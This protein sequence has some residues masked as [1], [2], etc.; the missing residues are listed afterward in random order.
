MWDLSPLTRDGSCV[1]CIRRWILNHWTT[2]EVPW[3]L[4]FKERESGA[5]LAVEWLRLCSSDA[6][7]HSFDPW[8]GN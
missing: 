5:Y 7:R 3:T 6:G 1:T 4:V 8:S 2:K